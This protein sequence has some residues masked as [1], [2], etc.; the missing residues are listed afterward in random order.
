MARRRAAGVLLAAI[1]AV[2]G[3]RY[4]ATEMAGV[5]RAVSSGQR[6]ALPVELLS[7][8]A[9]WGGTGAAATRPNTSLPAPAVPWLW[10][11]P[12]LPRPRKA[13]AAAYTEFARE[14]QLI[15]TTTIRAQPLCWAERRGV[16]RAEHY[17]TQA[18]T[19]LLR[20]RPFQAYKR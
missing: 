3:G 20:F 12:G 9:R 4:R 10:M 2:T 5:V 14:K 16:V 17:F 13:Q 6:E 8:G 11:I 15:T 7:T 18:F 1:S 19:A